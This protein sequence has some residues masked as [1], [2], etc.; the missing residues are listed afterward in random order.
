MAEPVDAHEVRMRL[1]MKPHPEGGSYVENFRDEA[2]S[3]IYFLL[4]AGEVS[5]W[6][7]LHNAAET[8]HFHAGAPLLLT[9]SPD[10]RETTHRRLG[11]DLAAGQRPQ[12]VV[13]KGCWQTAVTLGSWT[14]AGCTVA[15]A[16][17]FAEFELA[18][19]GWHPG[20]QSHAGLAVEAE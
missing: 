5:T 17:D 1:A 16:F 15:P 14:L 2:S 6:H 19:K 9:L 13:P 7:R 8:W 11:T 12:L 20:P 10:G 3:A 18:P 4:E